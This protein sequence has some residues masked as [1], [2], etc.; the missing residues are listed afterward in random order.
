M[1]TH[2]SIKPV[3]F[4]SLTGVVFPPGR[5][6]LGR[7]EC[8]SLI[9]RKYLSTGPYGIAGTPARG[10]FSPGS[11]SRRSMIRGRTDHDLICQE[12]VIR[13]PVPVRAHGST[14]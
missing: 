2:I 4:I 11:V 10:S 13:V 9:A 5:Y 8:D 3:R 7:V 12:L 14:R 1:K 6:P